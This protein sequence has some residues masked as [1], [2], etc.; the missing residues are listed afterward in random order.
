M[1]ASLIFL[2]S[3]VFFSGFALAYR[4]HQRLTVPLT[5]V[6]LIVYA[7]AVI[8]WALFPLWFV[9]AHPELKNIG[10]IGIGA[11]ICISFT[12]S[13]FFPRALRA[14]L[15]SKT[16]IVLPFIGIAYEFV[17][18]LSHLRVVCKRVCDDS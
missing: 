1:S 18:V 4:V 3:M 7:F 15:L 6:D 13:L 8:V 14:N 5:Q 10:P 11:S 9:S 17:V 16:I 2:G 12:I